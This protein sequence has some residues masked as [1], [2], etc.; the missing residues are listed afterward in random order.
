[1]LENAVG[2]VT[3]GEAMAAF[4]SEQ[5]VRLG[6]TWH[7]SVAG[8]EA[9]VAIGLARLGHAVEWVGRVGDDELG[10]L[11]IR[12]LRAEG[13]AIPHVQTDTRRQ[14]GLFLL[15]RR[16][17]EIT[18]VEYYR[19]NSAGS[20]LTEADVL[21]AL[22]SDVQILHLSG[23]T[24]AL[25]ASAAA[26]T[27][28]AAQAARR[29]GISVSLDVNYRAK[30]WSASLAR[31]ALRPLVAL[32][33]LL[34]VSAEEVALLTERSPAEAPNA[35]AEFLSEGVE[36][37]I[38]K[39]GALGAT[40][41]TAAGATSV[42]AYSVPVVD[43]VGAGDAFCAGYL[44]AT[45]DQVDLPDRLRRAAVMGAF[46]VASNGDWEGLPTRSELPLLDTLVD[47]VIR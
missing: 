32:A 8:A 23:I 21:S 11:I 19:A 10:G 46:A 38:I 34:F 42:D 35:V 44:S 22:H 3:F 9:N 41:Y 39:G 33:D 25:S 20:A 17:A 24:P 15:E 18:R 12:T 2:V 29:M 14:T 43:V 16:L 28:S 26:A 27:T 7:L 4:R 36:A 5:P 31:A 45:L 13:V 30:L 1:M 37:V 47:G 40:A 6:G